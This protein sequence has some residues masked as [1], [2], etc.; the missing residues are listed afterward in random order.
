MGIQNPDDN[1]FPGRV[2]SGR[3]LWVG[4]HCC[5]GRQG[6]LHGERLSLGWVEEGVRQ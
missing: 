2:S 5:E 1:R 3:G 6:H 4:R